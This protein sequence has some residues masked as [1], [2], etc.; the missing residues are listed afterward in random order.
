MSFQFLF[1]IYFLFFYARV[2]S[3][4]RGFYKLMVPGLMSFL[5]FVNYC[6]IYLIQHFDDSVKI[7][8]RICLISLCPSSVFRKMSKQRGPNS[9]Y[10]I[11]P[12]LIINNKVI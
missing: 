6:I 10:V 12:K 2:F 9:N 1:L 7:A 5:K 11:L 8:N 4:R 3:L